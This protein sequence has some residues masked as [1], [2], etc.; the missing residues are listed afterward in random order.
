MTYPASFVLETPGDGKTLQIMSSA[1][2]E[3]TI[4]AWVEPVVSSSFDDHVEVLGDALMSPRSLSA[5]SMGPPR[6]NLATFDK[7]RT[8]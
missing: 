5:S 8:L 3:Y 6:N 1:S 4:Y 2:M 7:K